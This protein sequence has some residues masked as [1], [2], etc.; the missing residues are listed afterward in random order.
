[1]N[2]HCRRRW[3]MLLWVTLV[4]DNRRLVTTPTVAVPPTLGTTLS[5][6]SLF[7]PIT[8]VH[9]RVSTIDERRIWHRF[10]GL[11]WVGGRGSVLRWRGTVGGGSSLDRQSRRHGRIRVAWVRRG[12]AVVARHLRI[13]DHLDSQ[14]NLSRDKAHGRKN[15]NERANDG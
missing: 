2:C 13:W 4:N 6:R 10:V 5:V 15:K 12:L 14:R 3:A 11:R 9:L 8:T 7:I 1:V